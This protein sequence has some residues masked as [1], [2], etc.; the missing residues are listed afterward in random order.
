MVKMIIE[1]LDSWQNGTTPMTYISQACLI[2]Q[3]LL[4][5][6][7]MLKGFLTISWQT[8]QK[9]YFARIGLA[10]SPKRWT[11]ALIQKMWEVAWNM[12][13]HR[14]GILHNKEQSIILQSLNGTIR[15]EFQKGGEGLPKE[16]WVLLSQGCRAVLAK[17]A[18]VKQQWVAWLQLAQSRAALEQWKTMAQWLKQKPYA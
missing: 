15:E 2:D 14:N 1:Y 9:T 7:N 13:E 10:R 4:G 17:S 18:E 6:R 11:I 8:I 5:W 16:A 12:W 3:S